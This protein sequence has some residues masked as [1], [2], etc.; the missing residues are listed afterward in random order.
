[1]SAWSPLQYRVYRALWIALLASNIGTW[2]QAVGAAWMMVELDASPAIVA[3]VQTATYLPVVFVGVLAGAAA[4]L[5]ERRRLLL[6]TQG[7]MLAA[8]GG[9]A[10]LTALDA[11]H[12]APAP[13]A[14][15]SRSGWARRSTSRPGRRSSRS[16]CPRDELKQAVTLGGANINL[17]RAIGPAIG[18]LL[19]AAA[20]PWLVFALNAASFAFVLVVLWRWKRPVEEDVG[21][22]ERFAGAVRA[23]VR[24]AMFSHILHGVL[25]RSFAFGVAS[26]GLMSLL[27]VYASAGARLGLRRPRHPVR[28]HGRRGRRD[29]RRASPR[30]ASTSAPTA[31]SPPAARSSRRR[32]SRW[33]S[34]TAPALAVVA[35]F[36]AGVGWLFCLSTLNVASQEVL[37][38]WVRARGLALYLTAISAGIALGS[39]LWGKLAH[40]TGVPATYAW[41][42]LAIVVTVALAWRWRFDRIADVDLRPA[43]MAAP[44]ARLVGGRG[45]RQPGPRRGRL[46]DPAGGRGRLPARPAPGRPG[47]PPHRRH[48]LVGLSRR[49]QAAPLH[50]DVRAAELG[51]AP[52]PAPAAHG[53]RPRAAGGRCA[54]PAPGHASRRRSTS[55]RRR[56]RRCGSGCAEQRQA[57][58]AALRPTRPPPARAPGTAPRSRRG[59]RR[60][61][62]AARRRAPRRARR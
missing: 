1:M 35:T 47:A 42:A 23:G 4:D 24:Y 44:E 60:C 36:V 28:R 7:F 20:G 37:P 30:C 49:G 19:I 53:H 57:P 34:C 51:R 15:R 26:A 22:P 38:G 62:R 25:V 8:A 46:R 9:L 32:S 18:G 13:R 45:R 5:V 61:A 21:P 3:L 33:R 48:R 27:P 43:P 59:G 56:S 10:V 29:R 54:V 39:A 58:A 40:A 6:I 41:G 11:G 52:A 12:A 55:S 2:M 31:C 17:G 50:R 16:W 14:S